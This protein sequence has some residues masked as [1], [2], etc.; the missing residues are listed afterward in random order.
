MDSDDLDAG[1]F[2]IQLS[3]SEQSDHAGSK[4]AVPRD[5]Q[6]EAAFQDVKRNYRVKVENGEIW[7]GLALPLGPR[8]TKPEAQAV[9]HAVE[10]LYFF[11]RFAEGARIVK[12]ALEGVQTEEG[13]PV[14]Q[15][16]GGDP[17]RGL[18]RDTKDTLRY[19]EKKC[20]EK[21]ENPDA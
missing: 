4:T 7:K 12:A 14:D 21:A 19:Y 10:E 1:L 2:G 3:D 8:T 17:R 15:S 18:D 13:D 5:A 9:L 6:S 16:D 11:G 20:L